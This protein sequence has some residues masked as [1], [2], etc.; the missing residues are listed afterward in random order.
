M[1]GTVHEF[2]SEEHYR[3]GLALLEGGHGQDGF[4]HLSRAYLGDPQSARFRSAYALALALVRGQF[5]GATELARAAVRQ[6]FYNPDLY[7]NLARIYL[8]FDFKA[9]A[10]RYLRRGL[11]VDPESE[12][13]GRKLAELGV[14]R[15]PAIRFLPR[16]HALNRLMGRLQ[17]RL[18]GPT[19]RLMSA[20]ARTA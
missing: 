6:E 5:L 13:L 9:E 7:L 17:A 18:L 2:T 1:H 20:V 14:R 4:E 15:R 12:R 16:G 19:T 8:A 3:R 10:V 11:M